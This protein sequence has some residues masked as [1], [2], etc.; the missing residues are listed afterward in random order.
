[1]GEH[2]GERVLYVDAEGLRAVVDVHAPAAWERHE[3]RRQHT[4]LA[5]PAA[6]GAPAAGALWE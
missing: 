2:H 5:P 3:R 4:A 1:V 6:A